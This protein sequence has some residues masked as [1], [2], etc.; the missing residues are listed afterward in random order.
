[1]GVGVRVGVGVGVAREVG[2]E[3]IVDW[4]VCATLDIRM[5]LIAEIERKRRILRLELLLSFT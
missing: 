2:V 1:M 4:T 5:E 3:E